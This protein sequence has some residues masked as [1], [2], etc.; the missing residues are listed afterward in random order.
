[1]RKLGA[2]DFTPDDIFCL[3]KKLTLAATMLELSR[4]ALLLIALPQKAVTAYS[5]RVSGYL[6][7]KHS[8]LFNVVVDRATVD[9]HNF[10]GAGNPYHLDILATTWAPDLVSVNNR[11]LHFERLVFHLT[12]WFYGA[13]RLCQMC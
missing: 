11:W 13:M 2:S 7:G 10:G 3:F 8:L 6:Y 4:V 9:I 12:G 1:M 5:Q